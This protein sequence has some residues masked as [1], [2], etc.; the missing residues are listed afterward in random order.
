MLL[1]GNWSDSREH[2]NIL[3]RTP[4][5][6]CRFDDLHGPFCYK[7]QCDT[8][9]A[10]GQIRRSRRVNPESLVRG[11]ICR[12]RRKDRPCGGAN[13]CRLGRVRTLSPKSTGRVP[14]AARTACHGAEAGA[15]VGG[16]CGPSGPSEWPYPIWRSPSQSTQNLGISPS[17][18]TARIVSTMKCSRSMTRGKEDGKAMINTWFYPVSDIDG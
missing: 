10:T 18:R 4:Q 12:R 13:L 3:A 14:R 11:S 9:I 6:D 1:L 17:N 5:M 2:V 7:N 16:T 8:I 15:R